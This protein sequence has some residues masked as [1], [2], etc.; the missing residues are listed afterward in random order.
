MPASFVLRDFWTTSLYCPFCRLLRQAL[1]LGSSADAYAQNGG[2]RWVCKVSAQQCVR[3]IL[4]WSPG[5]HV[6]Y[7]LSPCLLTEDDLR[8][9]RVSAAVLFGR[10]VRLMAK[11]DE[12][13][14]DQLGLGRYLNP[15]RVDVDL[16]RSWIAGCDAHHKAVCAPETWTRKSGTVLRMIDVELRC[17]VEAPVEC[18]YIVLSYCW[19]KP[20]ERNK[21][22]GLTEETISWLF[23]EGSLS[24]MKSNIPRTIRDAVDLVAALGERYLWVDALCIK[25]DDASDKARQIPL[26][27]SIYSSAVCTIVAGSGSDAWAGLNGIGKKPIPRS[28]KP[29]QAKIGDRRL[30]TTQKHYQRWKN[31]TVWLSRG[32]TFQE[33]ILSRR[34]MIF[35]DSQVFFQCKKSLWSEDTIFENFNSSVTTIGSASDETDVEIDSLLSAFSSY[36]DM[37]RDYSRR[38]F[39]FQSDALNAFQGVQQYLRDRGPYSEQRRLTGEFYFGLPESHFDAAMVWTLPYHYPNQRREMFPSWTWVGWNM[40]PGETFRREAISFPTNLNDTCREIVWYRPVEDSSTEYVKI[41]NCGLVL[42]ESRLTEEE[43]KLRA[44]WKYDKVSIPHGVAGTSHLLRFWTSTAS[45][46]VDRSG[47]QERRHD[48]DEPDPAILESE[49]MLIKEPIQNTAVGTISL[50]RSWRATRADKLDFIVV[51][52]A[53]K[54]DT[55]ESHGLYVMLI[56]WVGDVAYRVQMAKDPVKEDVWVSLRTQWKLISLA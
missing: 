17:V 45:L 33:R 27:G 53:C 31:E 34:L 32:W 25:Q 1:D 2:P 29:Y 46:L 39:A 41:D 21:H 3:Y 14:E 13:R 54:N 16:L 26:M 42:E 19:G 36:R 43:K 40:E 50:S 24:E 51:A 23:A 15:G 6:T 47:T 11:G 4:R 18:R 8:E 48:V 12:R 28:P 35:T 52:R 44:Q 38:S 56:E 7:E 10:R 9:G 49:E 22:L 37:V 30:T 55:G 20:S 5:H